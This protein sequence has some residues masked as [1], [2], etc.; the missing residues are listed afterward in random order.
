MTKERTR[1]RDSTGKRKH[2]PT[3]IRFQPD[4][5][6]DYHAGEKNGKKTLCSENTYEIQQGSLA[7]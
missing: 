3:N 6:V 7:C 1:E 4:N 5:E 2:A